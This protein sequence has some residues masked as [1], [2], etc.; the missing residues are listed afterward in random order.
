MV[1]TLDSRRRSS[2]AGDGD[3]VSV[4]APVEMSLFTLA[5]EAGLKSVSACTAG[6]AVF[7]TG[8]PIELATDSGWDKLS[9]APALLSSAGVGLVLTDSGFV[10]ITGNNR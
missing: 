7:S 2:A 10:E 4:G 8:S 5:E 3:F 1:L 6:A 9:V